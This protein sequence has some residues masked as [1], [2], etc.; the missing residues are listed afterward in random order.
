M[1]MKRKRKNTTIQYRHGCEQN[2]MWS[3]RWDFRFPVLLLV[4]SVLLLTGCAGETKSAGSANT[5][6]YNKGNSVS[7]VLESR[8]AE[9]VS[10]VGQDNGK[11]KGTEDEES[12]EDG[13]SPEGTQSGETAAFANNISTVD[14]DL[15]EMSSDMVYAMVYQMMME[16]EKYEGKTSG[17]RESII[18]SIRKT[19]KSI[20]ITVLS[21]MPRHAVPREWEFVWDDGSH[22]Y[23]DE[24]PEE[25]ADVIVEGTFETYTESGDSN[26]YCRL[27]D[28]SME[29][30]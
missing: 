19:R 14:Y 25:N 10:G 22:A 11:V 27:K 24:Y 15:T 4:S 1:R 23:P 3:F 9:N 26:L 16:P 2:P 5:G 18:R 6:N 7:G 21:R 8:T 20:T 29:V 17:W 13:N 30:E 28:A 12:L